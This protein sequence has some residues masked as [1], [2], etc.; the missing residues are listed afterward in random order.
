MFILLLAA[1]VV[2]FFAGQFVDGIIMLVA[3]LI[4]STISLFQ[5]YRSQNA[6]LALKKI[7]TPG[8]TVSRNGI[9]VKIATDELVVDDILFLEEGEITPADGVI[10]S[11]HDFSVN[12]SILTGEPFP[13]LKS[14][15]ANNNIYKGT[16]VNSGRAVAKITAVG[17]NTQFGK[18]AQSL[19]Q[20]TKLK[21]PL[22]L[23]INSF[24]RIMVW[25]GA[26]AF[27]IVVA[28][29]YFQSYNIL[30]SFLRGLTLAMSILPE[31]IPVALVTFQALG[32]LRLLRNN[33]IVKEPNHIETLGVTTVI[34]T[35]KTG[36]LTENKMS[37]EYLYDPV[38]KKSL[39][40][41]D[42][43]SIPSSLIEYAMWSSETNP[44]DPMEKAI[45]SMYEKTTSNDKRQ[46]YKQDHEYPIEGKPPMM[47][48]IF[49]SESGD[50]IVAA[51]GAPEA[52]LSLSN[53]PD[54]EIKL[55][56]EQST[57]YARKGYRVLGV[58]KA[59][60]VK[61][62]YPQS[63]DEFAFEFLGLVAFHDPPKRNI[64]QTIKVFYDAG[65]GVKMI[66]GDYA[67]T[68][69]A[70]AEQVQLASNGK[71]L[72]GQEVMLLD[73]T[74]LKQKMETVNIFARMFPE[75][76]LK[77]I[78]A[79]KERGEI[80]AMTGDGV[81]DAPALKAAHIGIAMGKRGSEVAKNAAA[82]VI[83]DDALWHM[84]EAIALGRKIYD[85]LK[86]AIRYIVSIHIPII[87]IVTIPLLFSWKF[88][89]IFTPIHV[90]FLELIM[91]PTCSIIYENEPME[92][93]TMKRPPRI[94]SETFLSGK[95]LRISIVQGLV[96]AAGCLGIGYI[97]MNNGQSEIV[98]RTVVFITLLISNIFLTLANRSFRYPVYKTLGYKNYLVAVVTG[99]SALFI[100]TLFFVPFMQHLFILTVIPIK[101]LII[102]ILIAAICSFWIELL[103]I[104]KK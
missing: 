14:P 1:C 25:S 41:N 98:I 53:L 103:K 84:T 6:I 77:V 5:D 87:L 13:V 19:K 51:K 89:N 55:Y 104:G 11:A 82:L 43:A 42:T 45:H 83:T 96:I 69:L 46:E 15:E 40:F 52:I 32:A 75:A 62:P 72:T 101:D 37:I 18:I 28:I 33:I 76:K 49:K 8:A 44:F 81:N 97:Y 3:I 50:L 30:S 66:T 23:Q 86:K 71:V 35:D 9:M 63:Q 2:Y 31:E 36:T 4:V 64:A 47:T 70:I 38:T 92:P 57:S 102:C 78:E 24:V 59:T 90:I 17:N 29:N 12:E 99:I 74:T 91:G 79:L 68:A 27:V 7:S 54:Q 21:T 65:I 100:A 61:F 22:Q 94:M 85:N 16:L 39:R 95:Q 93:G 26:L 60:N 80:V 67:E 88:S 58:G 73:M 20:I 34:C 48:H 10:I 56:E